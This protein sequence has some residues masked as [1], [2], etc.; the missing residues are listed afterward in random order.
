MPRKSTGQVTD[1]AVCGVQLME[2][3]HKSLGV[4]GAQK[5]LLHPLLLGLGQMLLRKSLQVLLLG[6]R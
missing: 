6:E 1:L 2:C 3:K 4:Q 5:Q